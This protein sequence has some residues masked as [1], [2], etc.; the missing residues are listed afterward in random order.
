MLVEADRLKLAEEKIDSEVKGLEAQVE[1][2]KSAERLS[3]HPDWK[4]F[5]ERLQGQLAGQTQLSLENYGMIF[6]EAITQEQKLQA[7]DKAR[8]IHIG[9]Y[10]LASFIKQPELEAANGVAAARRLEEIKKEKV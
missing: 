1:I 6:G 2:G 8:Q 9:L 10:Q 5:V 7:I 3:I 4:R